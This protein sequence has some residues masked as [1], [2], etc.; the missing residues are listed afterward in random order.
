[1]I[2]SEEQFYYFDVP[3]MHHLISRG[4]VCVL[5]HNIPVFIWYTLQTPND[6]SFWSEKKMLNCW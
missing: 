6:I 2:A 4:T 5:R 3:H 1:M